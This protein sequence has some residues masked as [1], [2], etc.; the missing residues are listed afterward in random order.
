MFSGGA[1]R[2]LPPRL[3]KKSNA[4]LYIKVQVLSGVRKHSPVQG[5]HHWKAVYKQFQKW[6][7]THCLRRPKSNFVLQIFNK[8]KLKLRM[9]FNKDK[10]VFN[11]YT[12][13]KNYNELM[14]NIYTQK[15]LLY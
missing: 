9:F 7:R 8:Q 14:K 12:T 11:V 10:L 2:K 4:G 3:F 15:K 13:A 1:C 6:G 5:L